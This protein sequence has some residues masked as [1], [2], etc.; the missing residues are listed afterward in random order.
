MIS[1]VLMASSAVL[2]QDEAALVR[3][4]EG[5]SV[6]V[7]IDMPATQSGV[8]INPNNSPALDL[9]SYSSRIKQYGIALRQGDSVMVTKVKVK[10]KLIEFQLGGGGYGTFGDESDAPE[11]PRQVEKSRR[12]KDLEAE[13]SRTSNNEERR[14][15]QR[16]IDDMR[17]DREREERRNRRIAQ[18]NTE[19]KRERVQSKRLSAGSRFNVLYNPSVPP[20]A[21]TPESLMQALAEYVSFGPDNSFASDGPATNSSDSA[22]LTD[23]ATG[24]RKGMSRSEVDSVLGAP[25]D[26]SE[27]TQDDL[28]MTT[29]TYERP[30]SIIRAEFVNGVLVR[31]SSSSR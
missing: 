27:R 11:I 22:Q 1:L 5:K 24:L 18:E 23:R 14:R 16:R 10:P 2:A 26:V 15:I 13:L 25:S 19:A 17:A 8:S 29:C 28:K 21:L 30:D 3:A 7:K 9:K 20:E 6:V 12:E 31:F 4:F